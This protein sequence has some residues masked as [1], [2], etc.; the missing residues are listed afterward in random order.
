MWLCLII[1]IKRTYHALMDWFITGRAYQDK[2]ICEGKWLQTFTLIIKREA[3][4]QLGKTHKEQRLVL[5]LQTCN[6]ERP[7][8]SLMLNS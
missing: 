8:T 2:S 1:K 3:V 5:R 6:L 4:K 7:E